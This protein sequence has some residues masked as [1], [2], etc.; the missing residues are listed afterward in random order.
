[1]KIK[2]RLYMFKDFDLEKV[3]N[4]VVSDAFKRISDWMQQEESSINDDYVKKQ[5]EYMKSFVRKD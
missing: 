1:M 4:I 5:V 2:W 3:P